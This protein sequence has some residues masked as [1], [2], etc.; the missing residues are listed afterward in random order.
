MV[1]EETNA[2]GTAYFRIEVLP[3]E[4]HPALRE[5]F[6]QYVDARLSFYRNLSNGADTAAD[7][8]RAT[9]L[10][11]DIW[12]L[13]VT[14]SHQ[15]PS[16]AVM[17][18]VLSSLNEMIDMTTTRTVA[19]ETHPPSIIFMMLG[20]L[21][22][23]CSLL[24]GYAM[25]GNGSHDKLHTVAFAVMMTINDDHRRLRHPGHRISPKGTYQR[26]DGGPRAEE[27]RQSMN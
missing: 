17:T 7:L 5:K 22:L 6:K 24:A 20:V 27:L 15:A 9:A 1:V 3:A 13:A 10:Q 14:R 12:A 21:I 16:P 26:G 11:H 23:T 2:I 25:A 18:L 19:L 8:V 4:A